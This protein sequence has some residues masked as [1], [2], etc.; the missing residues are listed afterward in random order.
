MFVPTSGA[1]SLWP[2]LREDR[3]IM[4]S[5][6]RRGRGK[7][8][9]QSHIPKKPSLVRGRTSSCHLKKPFVVLRFRRYGKLEVI[10]AVGAARGLNYL[11]RG[12]RRP[13][14]TD[15]GRPPNAFGRPTWRQV[16]VRTR[17]RTSSKEIGPLAGRATRGPVELHQK[18]RDQAVCEG[19]LLQEK[20]GPRSGE[21]DFK[22]EVVRGH[23]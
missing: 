6:T 1:T 8:D 19:L 11:A 4:K 12:F 7:T 18:T 3:D 2:K 17:L 13:L 23:R 15:P 22:M 20:R 10:G 16:T 9:R 14:A 21:P 5:P